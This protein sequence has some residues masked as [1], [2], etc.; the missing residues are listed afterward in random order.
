MSREESGT[1][2]WKLWYPWLERLA[3]ALGIGILA[4]GGR[5][6]F[7]DIDFAEAFR[8]LRAI[9]PEM[10]IVNALLG[11]ATI[12]LVSLYD[13]VWFRYNPVGISAGQIF[14]TAWIASAV[15]NIACMG[16]LGGAACRALFYKRA[17]LAD[18]TVVRLNVMLF[19]SF[20]SGLG[21]LMWFN[22]I[23]ARYVEAL[24][25]SYP[26]IYAVIF[27]FALYLALYLLSEAIPFKRLRKFLVEWGFVGSLRLKLS[28]VAVSTL[29]WLTICALMWFIGIQFNPSLALLAV[30]L[31]FTLATCIGV[32]SPMPAG[33]GFFDIIMMAGLQIAGMTG[34]ESVSTVL[35]FRIFFHVLPF[36]TAMVATA[37][38]LRSQKR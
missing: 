7:A 25:G 22:L 30:I 13:F 34:E 28:M 27:I 23:G 26:G 36:V 33:L 15:N 29:N 8:L 4:W 5:L 10:L 6:F 38:T 14:S 17:G 18:R 9:R 19:P 21:A 16:G 20:F 1:S 11:H 24:R 31:F 12:S 32:V 37:F 2:K 3:V 35:M